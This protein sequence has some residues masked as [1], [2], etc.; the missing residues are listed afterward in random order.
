QHGRGR[1]PDRG[2]DPDRAAQSGHSDRPQA[3]RHAGLLSRLG[4]RA[5]ED[6]RSRR[7]ARLRS[8]PRRED[9]ARRGA[10]EARRG[11]ARSRPAPE[12]QSIRRRVG[13]HGGDGR[14]RRRPGDRRRARLRAEPVQPR[15]RRPAPARILVQALRLRGRPD[16]V[17]EPAAEYRGPGRKRVHRQLVPAEL[18]SLLRER[19]AADHRARPLD[20]HDPGAHVDQH[21]QEHRSDPRGAR[22]QDRARE[23]RQ[24]RQENG[25]DHDADRLGLPADR[26][27]RGD[28]LGHDRGL[29]GVRQ[30]R[31]PGVAASGDRNPQLRGRGDL[32]SGSR[33]STAPD[34][35]SPGG[36][37]HELHAVQGA[38]GRHGS[39]R[40]AGQHQV[41]GQDRHDQRL[42]RRL[43]CGIHGQSRHGS[44]V[45]QRRL[46]FDR[47][48]DRRH[49]SGDGLEGDH[50]VCAPE[51]GDSSDPRRLGRLE[52]VRGRARGERGAGGTCRDQRRR[53]LG[54]PVAA[55]VR[56][57]QR[58]RQPARRHRAPCSRRHGLLFRTARRRSNQHRGRPRDRRARRGA[59]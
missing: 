20:Q 1:V 28:G 13:R 56:G 11:G 23:D 47:R 54:Q 15:D 59:L 4:L 10:A 2:P 32:P 12:R 35:G 55:L 21:R 34:P 49:P 40:R 42:P 50:G 26:G 36:R 25:S 52:R 43:V 57:D 29:C 51:P 3:R 33:G 24:P 39:P 37:G 5:G 6:A 31:A 8:R 17:A 45:R 53:V 14:R 30:W 46:Q 7:Q 27:R 44:L 19:D 9:P 48:H 41:G 22:R 18:Q 16:G 58:H 38:R